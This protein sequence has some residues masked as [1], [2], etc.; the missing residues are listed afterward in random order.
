MKKIIFLLF[1]PAPVYLC[2][3]TYS[4][5][6]PGVIWNDTEGNFI[7]AHGG[8]ILK[9]VNTYYW[10]GEA[11]ETGENGGKAF[12]GVSCYSSTDLYNWK[13][14]GIALKVLA[15]TTS[16][17]QRACVIE[18]PKVVYNKKTKKF[19]MWF[20][21]ELKDKAYAAALAGCAVADKITGPYVYLKS[22]RPAAGRWPVGFSKQM[23]ADTVTENG[24]NKN[25]IQLKE[26][27]VNGLYVRRDFKGGQ[28]SRDMTVYMD[29]DNKAYLIT[30]SEENQTLHIH[31]LSKDYTGFTGKYYRVFPGGRNEAPAI[32]K[33]DGRY[34]L[35]T[36]GLTGWKPNE[37]KSAV[38]KS[39]TGV[40]QSI[41]NPCRGT[42]AENKNTFWSQSTYIIPVHGK[43][44]AYIF[45]ADR[46]KSEN[47]YDSRYICLPIEF[48]EGKPVLRWKEK[49]T[50]D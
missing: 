21:H 10:F 11:K 37:G 45:M 9:Y 50:Y 47:L 4:A 3:Q 26:A 43:K 44:V 48:E 32:F 18:R 28:M 46:W 13:N 16:M 34:Y 38:A 31:E 24:L 49:W 29:D 33:K 27:V 5:F 42:D 35:F 7:N 8:G 12:K 40:W 39:L 6:E 20:H 36:S 25:S 15:D 17:L 2:A 22:L 1:L 23:Q 30:A 19:V 14:E 41:G